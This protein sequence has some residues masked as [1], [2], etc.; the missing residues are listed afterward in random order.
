M[1]LCGI[2]SAGG[3]IS[4]A[5]TMKLKGTVGGFPMVF[6]VDSGASHNFI[7]P[8]VVSVLGL[9]MDKSSQLGVRLGDGHLIKTQGRVLGMSIQLGEFNDVVDA[10][11]MELGGI[12]AILGVG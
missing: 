4:K 10:Y 8:E 9:S 1:G 5:R 6:L 11:I 7:S 12:D 3:G 2:S